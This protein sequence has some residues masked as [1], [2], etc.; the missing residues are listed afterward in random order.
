MIPLI[1][2][3][4]HGKPREREKNFS[5]PLV[6]LFFLKDGEHDGMTKGLF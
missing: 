4:T 6:K 3:S 1:K 2:T 5:D